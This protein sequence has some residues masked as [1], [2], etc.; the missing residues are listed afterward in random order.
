M[1]NIM[2]KTKWFVISIL[3]L[4]LAGM[5][6]LGIFGFNN[7]VD[8]SDSVEIEVRLE[9]NLDSAKPILKETADNFFSKNDIKIVSYQ[10]ED[11][12]AG[13]IYKLNDDVSDKIASLEGELNSA[14][15]SLGNKASAKI[16]FAY[17]DN[18]LQPLNIL[19]AYGIAIVAIFLYM[20]IMNKLAS[21]VAVLCASLLSVITFIS[22]IALT[23]IPALPYVE[24]TA[25]FAGIFGAILSISTV[26]KYKE[27]IKNSV[28]GKINSKEI[29]NKVG[30]MED[31]KYLFAIIVVLVA[32]A[33][34]SAFFLPYLMIMGG[35]IA[36]AGISAS[37]I[38]Y[39]ITPL[40]WSA[41]KK[42]KSR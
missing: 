25:M 30:E 15:S 6:I 9:Q 39:S 17:E 12:G 23:R 38:A 22:L 27:Q 28:N 36:L 4:I 29:A 31:K 11:D 16:N 18:Y 37:L 41:I 3:I 21:A 34:L 24:M 10:L 35:Q 2:S 7:T 8:Y 5:T 19:L 1:N 40:I 33:A 14:L 26:Q 32:S 13:I 20:L 42:N